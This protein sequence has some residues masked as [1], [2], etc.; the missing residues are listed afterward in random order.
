MYESAFLRCQISAR[1][2]NKIKQSIKVTRPY[3][4]CN[5]SENARNLCAKLKQ[6]SSNYR[7]HTLYSK[8][9]R[10][11]LRESESDLPG[12]LGTCIMQQL[13]KQNISGCVG[14][15]QMKHFDSSSLDFLEPTQLVFTAE[16]I[17]S[18]CSLVKM[19]LKEH[20][21]SKHFCF[22][23]GGRETRTF[24]A[25]CMHYCVPLFAARCKPRS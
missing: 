13:M 11:R 20:I 24:K 2:H 9:S 14:W 17:P 15:D 6:F 18:M 4:M 22:C 12:G 5:V 16:F 1:P 8:K 25:N 3:R 19:K 10:R 21:R 23:G 7:Q